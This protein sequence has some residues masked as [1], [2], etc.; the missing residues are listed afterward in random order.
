MRCNGVALMCEEIAQLEVHFECRGVIGFGRGGEVSAEKSLGEFR[1]AVGVCENAGC[2]DQGRA[3][4]A[5]ASNT[6]LESVDHLVG[7]VVALVEVAEVDV[8]LWSLSGSDG[9]SGQPSGRLGISRAARSSFS[10]RNDP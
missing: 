4:A 10:E 5:V 1:R 6:G 2:I 7:L 9:V 3:F 8:G